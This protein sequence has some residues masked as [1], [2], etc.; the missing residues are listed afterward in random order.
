MRVARTFAAVLLAAA[1]ATGAFTAPARAATDEYVQYYTVAAASETLGQ[2]ATRFLG[3]SARSTDIFNLNTGRRQPDGG[4]LTDG[5]KLHAG[6]YLTLPWDAVGPGV[7]HGIL[8]TGKPATKAGSSGKTPARSSGPAAPGNTTSGKAPTAGQI[9]AAGGTAGKL[10]GAQ[11]PPVAGAATPNRGSVPTT[12]SGKCMAATAA[13]KPSDWG[14][15]RMAADKAW[16]HSRGTGQL[17]AIIDSGVDGRAGA[18]NNRVAIGANIVTGD[19]RGDTDCLGSGTAM[20]GLIAAEPVDERKFTGIAPESIIMPVRVATDGKGVDKVSQAAAIEVAVS[21]GATVIALGSYVDVM[22]DTVAK[23]V[24]TALDHNIVVVAGAPVTGAAAADP[25]EGL[26]LVAGVAADGKPAARY[27][28]QMVDLVAPGVNVSSIGANGTKAF[29]GTGTQYA[30]AL[31]AGA[32][33]LV[34]ASHPELSATQVAHRLTVTSSK[35][36]GNGPY[37]HGMLNPVA[38]ITSELS[39]ETTAGAAGST[40]GSP[41]SGGDGVRIAFVVTVLAALVLSTLL[42]FRFRRTMRRAAAG[43]GDGLDSDWPAAARS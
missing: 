16:Q 15:T 32:A 35:M 42:V 29:T 25:P 2:I 3:S 22:Q 8:P 39:E 10:P 41:A 23:A 21:A 38:A 11:T 30:V 14:M 36:K 18:L 34:R 9:A 4:S 17:V 20:A 24:R 26:L 12:T 6:W 40:P 31:A 37:G 13:S 7:Q 43:G 5:D 33:A 1:L 19:G 28:P 27:A